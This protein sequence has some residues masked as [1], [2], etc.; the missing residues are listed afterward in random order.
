MKVS[1]YWHQERLGFGGGY[2]IQEE[3]WKKAHFKKGKDDDAE[4]TSM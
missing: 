4:K 1:C 3:S 2:R